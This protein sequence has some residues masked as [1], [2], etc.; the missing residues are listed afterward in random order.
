[1]VVESLN[2]RSGPGT[3]YNRIGAVRNGDVV[4]VTGQVKNCS[5]LQVTTPAGVEGWVS[6]SSQYVTLNARCADIPETKAPAPPP[7]SGGQSGSSQTGGANASKGCYIF[8]NFVGPE[9]TITFTNKN[10]GKGETFKV[11][12]NGEV[13]KCFDPGR[14]TYTLD[15]PPPWG[16]TN[17]ELT[18]EAGDRFLFPITPE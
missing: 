18:V 1:M 4:V 16:S 17:G 13:E 2:V 14:Y 7:S 12:S 6:G 10:T 3:N 5:W 11:A 15:A 8:Q 9:L